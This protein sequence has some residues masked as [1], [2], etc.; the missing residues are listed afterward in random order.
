MKPAPSSF[1]SLKIVV[2][3]YI[4]GGPLGGLVW[5]HLQY[6]LGLIKMGHDVIFIED[7]DDYPSCYNPD[8]DEVSTDPSYGLHF[9]HEVF[10]HFQMM[11]KWA[12]YHAP[13]KNWFGI[14]K[15][16]ILQFCKTADLFLN[17]S[18]INPVREFVQ[19]IPVRA[20]IDTDPAFTQVRHLTEPG[21][22]A[23][24]A[25][26]NRF[27]TFGENFGKPNC[28]VPDDGFPWQPTRQPVITDLWQPGMGNEKGYWTTVMQWDS[29][30]IREHNGKTF[31][32]K[33]ASFDPYI[34]LAESGNNFFEIALGSKTA[35]KDKLRQAGWLITNSLT[36]TKTPETYQQY[37]RS[38]KG[39]WSV[40]K[41]GY[42]MS[43]SGWFSERSCCYLASGR[44]V[45]LQDTGFSDFLDTGRGLL[46]FTNI[47]EAKDCIEEV[48]RNYR[49]HCTDA[50]S[51]AESRFHYE[52]VLNR[53]LSHCMEEI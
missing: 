51:I 16:K 44:P 10:S 45:V 14:D 23:I 21:S 20:F 24:A 9:I 2:A 42:V 27:F 33:S 38:S 18:G 7:S 43:H 50:R 46:S 22:T 11:D 35:P 53:L 6:V 13:T 25:K 36:V 52:N 3:G 37:I 32:M 39:E 34:S 19:K 4:V 12:Y 17:L 8:K 40:A 47:D 41:Q 31:G 5:H 49:K 28:S 15:K 29:Y 26:H 1:S 48:N 30:K